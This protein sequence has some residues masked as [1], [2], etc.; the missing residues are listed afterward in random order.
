M[1]KLLFLFVLLVFLSCEKQELKPIKSLVNVEIYAFSTAPTYIGMKTVINGT[2]VKIED[3][4]TIY[5]DTPRGQIVYRTSFYLNEG[6]TFSI[7]EK[8]NKT[9][10]YI[11]RVDVYT[12]EGR[13]TF[14]YID[15]ETLNFALSDNWYNDIILK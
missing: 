1:K 13:R 5:F 11:L 7:T 8:N 12:K 15:N 10:D 9:P 2:E 4:S 6:Q 14:H 3:N